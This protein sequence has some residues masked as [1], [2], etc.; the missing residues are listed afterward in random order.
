MKLTIIACLLLATVL[1]SEILDLNDSNFKS[2]LG[3]DPEQLWMVFFHADWVHTFVMK[4][5]SSAKAC[6]PSSATLPK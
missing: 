1:S 4:S 3:Q 6:S 5:A 2:T